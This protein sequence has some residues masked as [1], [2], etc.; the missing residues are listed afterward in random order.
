MTWPLSTSVDNQPLQ[1]KTCLLN[2][3]YCKSLNLVENARCT[4][5]SIQNAFDC[6][7]HKRKVLDIHC[8]DVRLSYENLSIRMLGCYLSTTKIRKRWWAILDHF[9]FVAPPATGN[10]LT[11][12]NECRSLFFQ[13]GSYLR[14]NSVIFANLFLVM[15]IILCLVSR[16]VHWLVKIVQIDK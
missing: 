16:F 3:H 2:D 10:C 7:L 8:D 4:Y 6:L 1:K 5:L 14:T 9:V 11:D 12:G 13:Q 15:M